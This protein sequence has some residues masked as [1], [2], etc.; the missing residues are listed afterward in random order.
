M[1][2]ILKSRSYGENLDGLGYC[3]D[4]LGIESKAWFMKEIIHK[5]DFI[6]IKNFFSVKGIVKKVKRQVAEWDNVFKIACLITDLRIDYTFSELV[7]V[8]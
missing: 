1:K 4:F 6:K 7:C 5:L 3:G 8:V 2:L